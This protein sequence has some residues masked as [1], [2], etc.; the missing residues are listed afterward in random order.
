MPAFAEPAPPELAMEFVAGGTKPTRQPLKWTCAGECT[1]STSAAG[2][3]LTAR[4]V[5]GVVEFEARVAKPVWLAQIAVEIVLPP[6][7]VE[8]VGRD[9]RLAHATTA[10]FGRFD[11]KW[12]R[13]GKLTV[14]AD[15]EID[16]FELTPGRLRIGLED[17]AAR[18]F[19]HDSRC[20]HNWRA[21]NPR[22]PEPT[23]LL[24]AG[25]SRTARIRI[26]SDEPALVTLAWPDGRAAALSITDH[27]DQSAPH[28][29]HAL[30]D[31][32]SAHKL[33][34]TKSLFA[35]GGKQRPQ[36][37]DPRVQADAKRL[38][39]AGS[40]I[41]PHSATPNPDD[42]KAM[43]AALTVFDAFHARTYIDHQPE[44]NCEA[45]F[46]L[47]WHATGKW[48]IAPRLAAHGYVYIWA[49][50][51]A[52]PP[53][54]NLF[55]PRHLDERAPSAYPLGRVDAAGPDGLWLWRSTWAFLDA[56]GMRAMYKP[57]ALDRLEAERG[58]HIAHT[59]LETYHKL[60]THF[61]RRN[62]FI[63]VGKKHPGEP[64]P[65]KP[66]PGFTAI[67]DDLAARQE[68]G[69]LWVTPLGSLVDR[70]RAVAA[71]RIR[72]RD[73]GFTVIA[74]APLEG[75]T[76]VLAGKV[77]TLTVGGAPPK[78][79]RTS[80][81]DTMFWADLPAGDTVIEA[82]PPSPSPTGA[83]KG[84]ASPPSPSP[85]GARKGEAH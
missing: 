12:L 37:E 25:E 22:V 34:I 61:G 71:L 80:A 52:L 68:R 85:T 81:N 14:A 74:P 67:L 21:P 40:E 28:T 48:S 62:L 8:V 77:S 64:G 65:V 69:T 35:V 55:A 72:R 56:G 20:T 79:S 78:G 51:D 70:M 16:S 13:V 42:H 33:R 24:A 59:Y 47:G 7:A 30:V 10:R 66:A 54:L 57:E 84:E 18:T 32:L 3:D 63:P 2:V 38:Y 39:D 82:S 75:A 41:I 17:V 53:E 27:A 49:E 9:R 23:R 31:A 6:G 45:F 19:A 83:R 1:A 58:L 46:N 11:P 15:D 50:G 60:R 43:D 73:G 44:T 5:N 26:G 76:F 4:A 29:F 36:L